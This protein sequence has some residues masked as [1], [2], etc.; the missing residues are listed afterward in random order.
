MTRL[1]FCRS[2]GILPKEAAWPRVVVARHANRT[3]GWHLSTIL[4]R[5]PPTG[6]NVSHD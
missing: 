6:G 3:T 1:P 5:G 4:H 2:Y